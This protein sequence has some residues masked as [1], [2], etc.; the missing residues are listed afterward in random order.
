MTIVAMDVHAAS[1]T[2]VTMKAKGEHS[3]PQRRPMSGRELINVVSCVPGPKTVVV[4]EG[5]TAQWIKDTLGDFVE[6]VVIC[7]PRANRLI[8]KAG[9]MNDEHSAIQLGELYLGGYT[10][11]VVHP[12]SQGAELRRLFNHY[13]KW[14]KH[15][16]QSKNQLKAIFRQAGLQAAGSTPYAPGH[17]RFWRQQLSG[18]PA[19]VHQAELLWTVIE[20]LERSKSST[21]RCAR[22]L[23]RQNRAYKIVD[24]IVGADKVISTGYV[25]LIGS[26]NRFSRRNQLW[27]YFGYGNDRRSSG[28]TIDHTDASHQGNRLAKWLASQHCRAVLNCREPNRFKD[29]YE[30]CLERGLSEG[31][32]TRSTCRSILSVVRALWIK[33]E[34]YRQTS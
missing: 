15:L 8:A 25:A 27:S 26:A 4:E 7:D 2:F 28:S 30:A 20:L 18:E 10:K 6:K 17:R 31:A 9:F 1:F 19:L 21:L 22:R 32:A 11:E 23:A 13:Y 16:V 24:S 29:H 3:Q 5:P 34:N 12:Q 33:G 14:N